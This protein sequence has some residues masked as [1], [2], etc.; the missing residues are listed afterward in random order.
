M[1]FSLL[2]DTFSER[3]EESC[4]KMTCEGCQKSA[5]RIGCSSEPKLIVLFCSLAILSI[6]TD[7]PYQ[8]ITRKQAGSIFSV[9]GEDAP[10][11][12]Y[13]APGDGFVLTIG[14]RNVSAVGRKR[15]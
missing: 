3:R 5:R 6:K 7:I 1:M 8:Q 13:S 9:I 12:R 14:A 10:L 11:T 15:S 4:G 2:I